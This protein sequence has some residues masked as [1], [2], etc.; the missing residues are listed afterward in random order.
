MT[1]LSRAHQPIK[2]LWICYAI[3]ILTLRTLALSIY[4]LAKAFRQNSNWTYRQALMNEVFK[5]LFYHITQVK[6]TKSLSLSPGAEKERYVM[7]Q[8]S[9]R[10]IY[11]GI[12][13]I[14]DNIRPATVGGTWYPKL[15]QLSDKHGTVFLHF[16]GGSFLWGEGRQAE[17][18]FAASLL[19]KHA[20]SS[21]FFVQYRLAAESNSAFPAALQDAVTAYQYLL[22][23][24]ISSANIVLS[25]DSA[26]G[27]IATGLLRYVSSAESS[28]PLPSA[29]LLWSPS[30]D[31]ATQCNANNVDKHR[32]FKTD[33]ITGSTLVWGLDLY[34][35]KSISAENP[36]LSPARYPFA[37][38][39][40]IWVMVG[41]AEVLYDSTLGFVDSMRG[42]D[43]NE[44]DLYEAPH[45]PHDIFFVGDLMGWEKEA[46][47]A[48]QA[49]SAFLRRLDTV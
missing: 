6:W 12:L 26:G 49:A 33:Y 4:F 36:Y 32:N 13:N 3:L 34:I 28:L 44:V 2:T 14:S 27:N 46:E 37:A 21:A 7:M 5:T 29:L 42:V 31:L 15:F 41:E 25:G 8:P 43:G 16:H 1:V 40:P 30:V 39:T 22:D 20:P 35:P 17:C 19:L 24:G 48:A 9:T 23:L 47:V 18:G 38:R 11:H 10:D 45:G